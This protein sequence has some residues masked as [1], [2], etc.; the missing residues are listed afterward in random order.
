MRHGRAK[1]MGIIKGSQYF[2]GGHVIL[3]NMTYIFSIEE[4]QGVLRYELG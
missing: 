4:C 2:T 3:H 1:W